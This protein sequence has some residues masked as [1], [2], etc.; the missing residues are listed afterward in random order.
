[1]ND[2]VL[3]IIGVI[4]TSV[5]IPLIT[6]LGIKLNAY[7]KTKI[8]NEEAHKYLDQA[9]NAVTIAVTC[10]AQTYVDSLKASGSFDKKAQKKAFESAKDK[11]LALITTEGKNAVIEL[12]GDFNEWLT[13][14]IETK[15]KEIK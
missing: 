9:A 13:A 14:Q 11:A 3:D 6:Y 5:I 8:K 7:L 10:V 4:A 12:Y 1:M 15:V 2:I